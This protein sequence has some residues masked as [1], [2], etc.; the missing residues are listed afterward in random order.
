MRSV[1]TVAVIG[2]RG[3]R[4]KDRSRLA[5]LAAGTYQSDPHARTLADSSLAIGARSKP[6][7]FRRTAFSVF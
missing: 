5:A 3:N 1:A 2:R 7:A 4:K 6:F